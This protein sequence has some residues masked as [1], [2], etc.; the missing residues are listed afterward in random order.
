MQGMPSDHRRTRGGKPVPFTCENKR[1]RTDTRRGHPHGAGN[2]KGSV[3]PEALFDDGHHSLWLEHVEE[4][5]S[6]RPSRSFWLMWYKD[7]LPLLPASSVFA[8][9]DLALMA[10]RLRT[11][12]DLA[13]SR[14]RRL[15]RAR[16][17][18]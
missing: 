4:P 6:A 9:K 11:A 15:E 13:V 5:S 1:F 12:A 2:A 14:K 18:R 17:R 10:D 3:G 8:A 16:P 7:G